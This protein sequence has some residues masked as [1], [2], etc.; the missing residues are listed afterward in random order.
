MNII[1]AFNYKV[2]TLQTDSAYNTLPKAFPKL[3]KDWC[4]LARLR[5][6]IA[7]LSGICS[8][9]YDCCRHSCLAYTGPYE[10]LET[11][12]FCGA[13]RRDLAGRP[14]KQFHYL[15]LV[16]RLAAENRN[17]ER[18]K[19]IL[20][21]SSHVHVPGE[22]SDFTD[23]ELYRN[24]L[25]KKVVINGK[26]YGHTY[27]S[28][29]RDI[30][31]GI[32]FD[33]FCPFKKRSQTCWPIIAFNYNLPPEIWFHQENVI[34][35]GT[36]PGPKQMKDSNSF[37][38][39]LVQELEELARGVKVYDV[40]KDE[41]FIMHA[42]IVLAFGDIPAA[43]KLMHM[44]GHNSLFPCRFCNIM[45]VRCT[46]S[47]SRALY[48]PLYRPDDSYD[49]LDLPLR[50]HDEFMRKARAVASAETAAE[51]GRL[52]KASGI[53]GI[54]ALSCLSSV[55]FPNSFRASSDPVHRQ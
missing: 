54:S 22:I 51:E 13:E 18:A 41:L 30:A 32:S 24:L 47:G 7:K 48:V 40:L 28:D 4:S 34:P 44:K 26:E 53:K 39:P 27:F 37:L 36:I 15:P 33:G 35:L 45:G 8:D 12:V 9:P 50:T 14:V 3:Q 2:A 17:P 21:R 49:P 19:L 25:G 31:L 55:S 46:E 29:P 42:Y 6:R 11:C 1:R 16:N 43:A 23:S 20:H 38:V 5:S 10:D 52:S